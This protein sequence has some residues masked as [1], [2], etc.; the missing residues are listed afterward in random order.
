MDQIGLNSVYFIN[1]P[2]KDTNKQD[3]YARTMIVSLDVDSLDSKKY[4]DLRIVL[5]P[6]NTLVP[7]YDLFSHLIW[8][9]LEQLD[10]LDI[11]LQSDQ[12]Q[13]SE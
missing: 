11:R 10:K 1:D 9:D 13:D 6:E 4:P 2:D 7:N 12:N 5:N 3:D 8:S